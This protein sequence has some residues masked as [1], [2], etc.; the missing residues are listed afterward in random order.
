MVETIQKKAYKVNMDV[1][2]VFRVVRTLNNY[3]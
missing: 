1:L 2:E 3:F